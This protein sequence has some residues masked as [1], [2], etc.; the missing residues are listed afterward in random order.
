MFRNTIPTQDV[1]TR[2]SQRNCFVS[3]IKEDLVADRAMLS[4]V[5][6]FSLR[7]AKG[8]C[9]EVEGQQFRGSDV[10]LNEETPRYCRVDEEYDQQ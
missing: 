5:E 10:W 4:L 6:L 8:S 9:Q 2:Q 1:T 3:R 7:L